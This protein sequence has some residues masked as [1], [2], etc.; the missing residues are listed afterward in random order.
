MN[1]LTLDLLK[2]DEDVAAEVCEVS[3]SFPL[4]EFVWVSSNWTRLLGP[5]KVSRDL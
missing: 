1:T 2:G 5:W 3:A 4:Q